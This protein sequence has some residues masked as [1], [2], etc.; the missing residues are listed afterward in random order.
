MS[1]VMSQRGLTPSQEW[2]LS[3]GS[4]PHF[5]PVLCCSSIEAIY[6]NPIP[7]TRLIGLFY[8]SLVTVELP[9]DHWSVWPWSLTDS[10]L[11]LNLRPP[12]ISMEGI[13]IVEWTCL[14]SLD[15]VCSTCLGM[16]GIPANQMESHCLWLPCYHSW[17]LTSLSCRATCPFCSLTGPSWNTWIL[18]VYYW[19]NE[20]T[21]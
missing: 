8:L 6:L 13:W 21:Y 20:F 4:P 3:W 19:N 16:V 10:A 1:L 7:Q 17:L 12:L 18:L 14:P 15:L 11:W 5:L 9:S 2:V